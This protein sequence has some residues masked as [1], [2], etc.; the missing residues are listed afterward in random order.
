MLVRLAL[1]PT[2]LTRNEWLGFVGCLAGATLIYVAARNRS[3]LATVDSLR[4]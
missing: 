1:L 4:S 3:A 2:G